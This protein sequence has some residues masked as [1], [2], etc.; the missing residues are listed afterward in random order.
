MGRSI[1]GAIGTA[2]IRCTARSAARRRATSIVRFAPEVPVR[3]ESKL[4]PQPRQHGE[5]HN[6]FLVAIQANS[7]AI[8]AQSAANTGQIMQNMAKMFGVARQETLDRE[9][10][11]RGEIKDHMSAIGDNVEMIKKDAATG[12]AQVGHLTN[13]VTV[14]KEQM[15]VNADFSVDAVQQVREETKSQLDAM[16]ARFNAMEKLLSERGAQGGSSSFAEGQVGTMEASNAGGTG[17]LSSADVPLVNGLGGPRSIEP[18][19]RPRL[20]SALLPGR[21]PQ[22]HR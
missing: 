5:T 11:L 10:A 4:I 3:P 14:M 2:G 17:A 8:Q 7:D 13:T 19:Q 15:D 1:G 21:C 18:Q 20:F 22:T 12:A 16:H 9:D 6:D